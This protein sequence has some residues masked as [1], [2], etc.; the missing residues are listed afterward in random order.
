[1]IARKKR[2]KHPYIKDYLD[3]VMKN[4]GYMY[5]YLRDVHNINIRESIKMFRKSNIALGIETGNPH[6]LCGLFGT[7]LAEELLGSYDVVEQSHYPDI[8]Y[9]I[10]WA[11]AYLQWYSNISFDRLYELVPADR[12]VWIYGP[13]HE[14]WFEHLDEFAENNLIGREEEI[15]VWKDDGFGEFRKK[16]EVGHLINDR[17]YFPDS[18]AWKEAWKD[19]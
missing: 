4:M 5:Q 13:Y 11:S 2:R 16:V 17:G 15:W 10:G 18:K 19:Y 12:F 1:M 6:Y 8:E 14:M 7:E 3:E 9:W